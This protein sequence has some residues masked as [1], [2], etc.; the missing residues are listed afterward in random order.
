MAILQITVSTWSIRPKENN[1]WVRSFE[2]VYPN[3]PEWAQFF[4]LPLNGPRTAQNVKYKD[5]P[6]K[7]RPMTYSY[8]YSPYPDTSD[9]NATMSIYTL[10]KQEDPLD[11]VRW[12]KTT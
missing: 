9:R 11:N 8:K 3:G 7:E 2:L 4:V 1:N 10:D 6:R 12:I 5:G